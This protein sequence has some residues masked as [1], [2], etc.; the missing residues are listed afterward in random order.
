MWNWLLRL[1]K[2]DSFYSTEE[3]VNSPE[4]C[5]HESVKVEVD[6]VMPDF[7]TETS[8]EIPI[9]PIELGSSDKFNDDR[10]VGIDKPTYVSDSLLDNRPLV[11]VFSECADLL[12]EIDRISSRFKSPDSQ[13]L[14][15]MINE[16]LRSALYLSGGRP[17]DSDE[18]F[19]PI[20]HVC[21]ENPM[22]IEGA[23][24]SEFIRSGV[25]LDTRVFIKAKV[26]LL[27]S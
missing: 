17:I 25:E 2:R 3:F 15:E 7:L 8:A 23:P 5:T 4:E 14:I 21:Q 24:I 13:L 9:G 12:S 10:D 11:K 1:F 16:R 27:D 18:F 20:R 6:I 22:A 19:D 26:K